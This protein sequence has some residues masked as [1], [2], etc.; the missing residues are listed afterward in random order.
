MS[1]QNKC[2]VRV[3]DDSVFR[4]QA[5]YLSSV[6]GRDC[7][8][9][10]TKHG[11]QIMPGITFSEFVDIYIYLAVSKRTDIFTSSCD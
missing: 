4:P 1:E 8:V 3:H 11:Y 9:A 2:I 7:G 6:S 10:V 5:L